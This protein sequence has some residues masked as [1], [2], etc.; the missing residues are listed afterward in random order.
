MGDHGKPNRTY[1]LGMQRR[2]HEVVEAADVNTPNLTEAHV[3][4]ENYD[5]APVTGTGQENAFPSG[6]AGPRKWTSPGPV[7]TERSPTSL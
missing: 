4:G 2:M 1:T 3:L 6:G 7:V 5:H